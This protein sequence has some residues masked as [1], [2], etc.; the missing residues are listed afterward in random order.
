MKHRLIQ[1]FDNKIH[2]L[3]GIYTGGSVIQ[4]ISL[5]LIITN[6]SQQIHSINSSYP[7]ILVRGMSEIVAKFMIESISLPRSMEDMYNSFNLPAY[8][9]YERK[10][11]SMLGAGKQ[12]LGMEQLIFSGLQDSGRNLELSYHVARITT[13][14]DTS[15]EEKSKVDED[16]IAFLGLELFKLRNK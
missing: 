12:I 6:T 3:D 7:S 2:Y 8:H 11:D 13:S 14:I 5:T 15:G 1:S 9:V 16:S 4:P 10:T